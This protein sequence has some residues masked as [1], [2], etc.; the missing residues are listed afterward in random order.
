M[1]EEN[2]KTTVIN[3]LTKSSLILEIIATCFFKTFILC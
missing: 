3:S 1:T 2:I